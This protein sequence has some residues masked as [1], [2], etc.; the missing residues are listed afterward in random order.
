M[1]AILHVASL[2]RMQPSSYHKYSPLQLVF[3]QQPNISHLKIFGCVVY[4]PVASPQRNKMGLQWRFGIYFGFD[5][6]SIIRYLEPLTE[7]IFTAQFAYCHFD[8]QA[9]PSLGGEK[10]KTN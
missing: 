9:F 6:P 5:S 2:I 3:G 4:V 1:H 10:T 8:E 7:D